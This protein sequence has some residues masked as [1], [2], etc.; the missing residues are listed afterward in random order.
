MHYFYATDIGSELYELDA[1]QSKHAVKSQRLHDGD[2]V[3]LLDGKGGEYHGI[4]QLA[5]AKSC[6]IEI[7]DK[8]EIQNS[9]FKLQ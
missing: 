5:D 6:R 9:K 7:Q 4:I 3:V 2:E 1:E 8:Q